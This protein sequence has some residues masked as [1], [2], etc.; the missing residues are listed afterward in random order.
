MGASPISADG[1]DRALEF[2]NQLEAA[3]K[4]AREEKIVL[5]NG[6]VL[7]LRP[8]S[9]TAVQRA[10]EQIPLPSVPT[11]W[12]E[13]KQR[14]EQNPNDPDYLDALEQAHT[15]RL[16][17]VFTMLQVMGT[18]FESAPDEM[19]GPDDD[20][21]IELLEA[22]GLSVDREWNKAQRYR[23]WLEEYALDHPSDRSKISALHFA[24]SGINEGE[25]AK[26]IAFLG[27]RGMGSP[28]R[29]IPS[30]RNSSKA[31]SK[32]R[33]SSRASSRSTKS[34]RRRGG[35]ATDGQ[36]GSAPST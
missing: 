7:R 9:S 26:A 35:T 14:D 27:S 12:I 16:N 24:Y 31:G 30:P 33:R 5:S 28:S 6:I 23:H 4:R 20:A 3:A 32:S 15:A 19:C 34:V 1:A 17:A 10:V 18:A 13:D 36:N 11:T 21:W 25:V 22:A 8:V 2:V 29:P